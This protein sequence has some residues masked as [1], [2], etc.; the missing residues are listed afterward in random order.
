MF[1][2]EIS[3]FQEKIDK[4]ASWI[5]TYIGTFEREEKSTTVNNVHKLVS[6]LGI[7][8]KDFFL[9]KS[10]LHDLSNLII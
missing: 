10:K 7:N 1:R 8:A 5:R 3:L 6:G 4:N 9:I 2:V